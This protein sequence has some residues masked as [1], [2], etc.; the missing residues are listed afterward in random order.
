M[1]L[2]N[3]NIWFDGGIYIGEAIDRNTK[4]IPLRQANGKKRRKIEQ[5]SVKNSDH[6][7]IATVDAELKV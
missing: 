6:I 1:S 4:I 5:F 3:S 7:M 2:S